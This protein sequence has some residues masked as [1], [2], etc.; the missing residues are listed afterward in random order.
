[1]TVSRE[2]AV[3]DFTARGRAPAA[4]PRGLIA[5][6]FSARL[7]ALSIANQWNGWAGYATPA[8]LN[9]VESEYFAI[10]N[11]ATLFDLSPM[12]KY[13]VSGADAVRVVNRLVTRDVTQIQQGRVGYALW[14]D[15]NGMVIDDGTVFRLG[16]NDFRVCC[17]ESQYSW[18]HQAAWGFDAEIG[19]ESEQLAALALQGPTSF[20]LLTAA[21][22]GACAKLKPFDLAEIEPGLL[23]S[24]TGFT[25]D[26]GYELWVD[27]AQALSLW[28][29]LWAAG[30][31][32]GVRAIGSDALNVARIEAGFI[33]TGVDFKSIHHVVRP[34]RGRTPFELGLGRLV[35]FEKG[36]FNG[37]RALLQSRR[38]GNRYTL[39]SLDVDGAKPATDALIYYRNKKIA[40]HITSAVWSPTTKRNIA[41]GELKAPYGVSRNDRLSVEIYVD[42]EGKWERLKTR[43]RIVQRP[44]FKNARSRATPPRPF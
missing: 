8:V 22:L 20:S 33:A 40:G 19:D 18:L 42:K 1:M 12:Y 25:G 41:F 23:I 5:T 39:V 17:Q 35:D 4:V 37:R 15:E 32:Y 13:R 24:R 36:H 21:G 3:A 28:D 2:T 38:T 27:S 44:L 6:P 26:L 9:S 14:C 11:Q 31:N 29:R 43:V 30:G 16:E 34:T 7:R 10:R